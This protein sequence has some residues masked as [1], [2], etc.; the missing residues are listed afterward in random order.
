MRSTNSIAD[1]A[2]R[3]SCRR[4]AAAPPW[5]TTRS[6][7]IALLPHL[8]L[9]ALPIELCALK[10]IHLSGVSNLLTSSFTIGAP[11]VI[12]TRFEPESFCAN[13]EKYKVAYSF[14]VPPVLV[15]L[16]RHPGMDS[17]FLLFCRTELVCDRLA[18]DKYDL[19]S[20]EYM[21]SGAAP[22]GADLVKMVLAF[23]L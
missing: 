2:R 16:A 20:L 11:V 8:R 10:L 1:N 19:S 14:V 17:T 23:V 21:L 4:L 12:Q 9:V 7:H 3:Y 15:V 6:R 18:V 22:L 13:I 5:G